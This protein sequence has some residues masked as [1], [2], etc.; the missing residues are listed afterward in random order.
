MEIWKRLLAGGALLVACATAHAAKGEI[1]YYKS[2]CDY[3]IVETAMGYALLEWY[4]GYDPSRGEVVAGDF[5]T[6]GMKEIYNLT[7]N[8]ETNVWVED[9]WLSK[10]RAIEE[11]FDKCD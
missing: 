5:E 10:D 3:F 4:G 11:Y 6:Y 7:A 8:Q 9:F 2:G 1:V